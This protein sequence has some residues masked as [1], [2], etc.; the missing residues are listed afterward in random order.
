MN[1]AILIGIFILI[2]IID[3]PYF[4]L[5]KKKSRLLTIYLF[6]MLAGMVLGILLGSTKLPVSISAIIT[7]IVN[8]IIGS[9]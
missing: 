2:I 1:T 6:I 4:V 3:F 7:N 9:S 5:E 8:L